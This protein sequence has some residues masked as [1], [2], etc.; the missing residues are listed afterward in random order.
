MILKMS[1]EEECIDITQLLH[2]TSSKIADGYFTASPRF[3]FEAAMRAI[4]IMDPKVDSGI[5]AMN[6]MTIQ[7]RIRNSIIVFFLVITR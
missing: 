3:N 2:D 6:I 1:S 7:E 4:D 5:G